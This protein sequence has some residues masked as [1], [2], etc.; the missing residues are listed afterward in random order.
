MF[1]PFDIW[2]ITTAMLFDINII[3]IFHYLIWLGVSAYMSA[4]LREFIETKTES[5]KKN[6][7]VKLKVT[8]TS[9]F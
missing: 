2:H 5:L 6:K 4:Q 9:Y 1:F 3:L 8:K 7:I